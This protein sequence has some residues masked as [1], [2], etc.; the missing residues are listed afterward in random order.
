[1]DLLLVL[2][3]SR[4]LD[5]VVL[6]GCSRKN[7]IIPRVGEHQKQHCY[8]KAYEYRRIKRWGMGYQATTLHAYQYSFPAYF[9]PLHLP[10]F[11][12]CVRASLLLKGLRLL[13]F[14][15]GGFGSVASCLPVP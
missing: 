13:A 2:S 9:N 15:G 10:M 7:E 12:A 14:R 11:I 8:S 6:L 4:G 5:V 1:M 3:S